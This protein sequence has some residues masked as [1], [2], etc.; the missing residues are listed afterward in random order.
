MKDF[1]LIFWSAFRG[2]LDIENEVELKLDKGK[3]VF[4][5]V[6]DYFKDEEDEEVEDYL[7]EGDINNDIFNIV[8]GEE[9]NCM[10][11]VNFEGVINKDL[12]MKNIIELNK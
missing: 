4:D 1:K 8:I 9:N 7:I 2:I 10:V 3:D 5:Y 11:F 12:I 6:V